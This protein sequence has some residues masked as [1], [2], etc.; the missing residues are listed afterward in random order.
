MQGH[1]A[2]KGSVIEY[3]TCPQ[4]IHGASGLCHHLLLHVKRYDCCH[5]GEWSTDQ[6][7]MHTGMVKFV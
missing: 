3:L 2:P 5:L 7:I 1:E 6:Q 4:A